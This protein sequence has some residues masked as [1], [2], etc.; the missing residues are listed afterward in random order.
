MN[1]RLRNFFEFR[2]PL[3]SYG[4]VFVV[5]FVLYLFNESFFPLHLKVQQ[6]GILLLFAGFAVRVLASFTTRYLGKLKITGIYA[7]C[8]QPLLLAQFI[9][10][11]GMNLI[12]SNYF[13]FIASLFIFVC[14]DCFAMVKYDKILAYHYRDIWKIYSAQTN[15]FLP[16]SARIK[17]I[18]RPSLSIAEADNSSNLPIFL[19]IYVI[20]I[21]IATLSNM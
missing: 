5:I 1:E 19:V 4:L 18:F 21:E 14:N 8:R 6:C 17:D 10:L 13:F 15:F 20:L 2:V 9:S 11:L 3:I 7:L 16:S 12:V